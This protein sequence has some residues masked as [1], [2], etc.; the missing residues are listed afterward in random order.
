MDQ[1]IKR[2]MKK[3]EVDRPGRIV[4]REKNKTEKTEK[5]EKR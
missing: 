4:G 5:K 2:K 1:L 3:F